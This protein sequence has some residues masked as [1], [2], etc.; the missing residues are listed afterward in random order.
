LFEFG[1]ADTFNEARSKLRRAE[2]T[3]ALDTDTDGGRSRRKRI[4][5]S[6]SEDDSSR[7]MKR[8]SKQ[9]NSGDC[10]TD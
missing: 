10:T 1:F 2:D 8:I 3:S 5:E 7:R 6:D 4:F 9:K